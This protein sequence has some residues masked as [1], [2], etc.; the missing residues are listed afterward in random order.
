MKGNTWEHSGTKKKTP[1]EREKRNSR[2]ARKIASE[3]IVLL[4]NENILPLPAAARVALLGCGAEH[5]VK[6]GIGSGDVNNRENISIYRG[7]KE[8]GAVI[9]SEDWLKDYHSRYENARC[10]WKQLVLQESKKVDN[11]FDAYSANPFR[12]P[13]GRAVERKDVKDA[14]IVCYVISRISGEGKDRRREAG[15]YYLSERESSDLLLLNKCGKPVILLINAGGP[16]EL[17]GILQQAENIKAV[18]NISQL[19]QEGGSAVADVLLGR[20]SPSGKLTDTWAKS[21]EDYP[22]ARAYSYLNGNT[23]KEWYREGI[24][25]G[26]RYFDRCKTE[27]LFAFG[28]GL[29]Y[30]DFQI[31][32]ADL[33]VKKRR[34]ELEAVIKNVGEKY[35]GKEVLQVYLTLPDISG[36]CE[37]KRLV[38]FAKTNELHPDEAQIVR[39]EIEQK[40]FASFSEK[41]SAW[42]VAGGRYGICIGNASDHL[43]LVATVMVPETVIIERTQPICPMPEESDM[44]AAGEQVP[45]DNQE[46][47]RKMLF[48]EGLIPEYAFAPCEYEKKVFREEER[49]EGRYSTEELIPLLYGHVAEGTSTLG[50]AGIQVPGSAGETTA[51]LKEKYGIRPMIMADGP[52]GIRLHQSYEVDTATDTVYGKSVL[53]ALENGFLEPEAHHENADTY[54]QYCTAFP[55]GTAMA[56]TWNKSYMEKFG[57][58]IAEEMKEF[59]VDIWLA[60]GM[61]IHRN[62][63][64]GRNFEYFSED[65]V[66]SGELAAAI[67]NG[68]QT[69]GECGVT[70]KHFACNNQEENR[71][72]VDAWVSERALREIY[73]RGFE[74]AIR[75]SRPFAIMTSYNLINGVHAAN[76]RD[77]CTTVAREEWGFEGIIMSD[78][79]TTASFGGSE[80]WKCIQAGNDII[81][82]GTAED[83]ENIRKA[84]AEGSLSEDAI[85]LCAG[86]IIRA[87]RSLQ[88]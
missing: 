72:G 1:S 26:Y 17:T 16:V 10:E 77:L 7:L 64:C 54:Y 85:R 24:Y 71:M 82:P 6:G 35:T 70:I 39:V 80:A 18:L 27:P 81:M 19:G 66:L 68:V 45:S 42:Y 62:P 40:S 75:Q 79:S 4:K 43:K 51:A 59:H 56:Q 63:L 73:F 8:A 36:R 2:L 53:G 9:T 44:Y 38:A 22:S 58:A 15:D 23:E 84:Y 12:M 25:V 46:I 74:I 29:S 30:T 67:T 47:N 61:N 5:T 57:Q 65:P 34:V 49:A 13:E 21:Y 86:R 37:E 14:D 76:S 11:P 31:C 60:P 41:H 88:V 32:F 20:V 87:V 78:W 48:L 52:A 33:T 28:H 69:S 50:A 83:G 55:V 3:A